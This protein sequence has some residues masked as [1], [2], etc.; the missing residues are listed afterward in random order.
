MDFY[1]GEDVAVSSNKTQQ[2]LLI[3]M[4]T[5]STAHSLRLLKHRAMLAISRILT[6]LRW[7]IYPLTALSFVAVVIT[8]SLLNIVI[9]A[10]YAAL[11]AREVSRLL[12]KPTLS[13]RV[14]DKSTRAP[15]ANATVLLNQEDG[16]SV[17]VSKA[18]AA[19]YFDFYVKEGGY[20]LQVVSTNYVLS[21]TKAGSLYTVKAAVNAK[22]LQLQLV[23][24]VENE[25]IFDAA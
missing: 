1:K 13:G 4:D 12:K 23:R 5:L 18:N 15:I 7:T 11:L 25:H 16:L 10:I 17:A 22:S 14:I 9:A 8:P 20:A 6:T 24:Q 2:S 19:G 3:P 21:E